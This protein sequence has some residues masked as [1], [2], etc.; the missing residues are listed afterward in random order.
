MH[1]MRWSGRS[2]APRRS[3]S[4]RTSHAPRTSTRPTVIVT[5]PSTVAAVPFGTI[6]R[7]HA[8]DRRTGR[9]GRA[10]G[11]ARHGDQHHADRAG[12]AEGDRCASRPRVPYAF[13][14]AVGLDTVRH[15]AS[16]WSTRPA[17]DRSVCPRT[18]DLP[19]GPPLPRQAMTSEGGR[20][21]SILVKV[22]GTGYLPSTKLRI[23][24][25]WSST[26]S[27]VAAVLMPAG[28]VTTLIASR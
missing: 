13:G 20:A 2:S 27:I 28:A 26:G 8:L 19:A 1:A 25:C 12:R 16:L 10:D 5:A 23:A 15:Q 14:R 21:P 11:D 7:M 4:P 24:A 9:A 6:V 17:E 3:N 18:R 22:S